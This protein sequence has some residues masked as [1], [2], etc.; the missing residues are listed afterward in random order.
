MLVT[1]VL[2][3][4]AWLRDGNACIATKTHFGISQIHTYIHRRTD[5]QLLAFLANPSASKHYLMTSVSVCAL[6]IIRGSCFQVILSNTPLTA[7][8]HNIY[9]VGSNLTSHIAV[10]G[11]L[12]PCYLCPI[13]YSVVLLS[14]LS[15]HSFS[16]A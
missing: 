2:D 9:I 6:P 5:I 12:L 11:I 1:H 7:I 4:S 15:S 3:I 10:H 8:F 16:L 14:H 13:S